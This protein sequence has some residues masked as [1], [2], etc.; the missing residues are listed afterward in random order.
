MTNEMWLVQIELYLSE[1]YI[2]D[3]KDLVKHKNVKYLI[4]FYINYTL[5]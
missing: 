5:K 3:F 1:K 4:D 2:I